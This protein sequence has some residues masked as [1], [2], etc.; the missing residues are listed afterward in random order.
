LTVL[1][2][3]DDEDCDADAER[4]KRDSE[5]DESDRERPSRLPPKL[6]DDRSGR[7]SCPELLDDVESLVTAGSA[8]GPSS[9]NSF[10]ERGLRRARRTQRPSQG[11]NGLG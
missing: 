5:R 4:E 1:A 8:S 11:V 3:L 9:K 7:G 2:E 10:R 6:R